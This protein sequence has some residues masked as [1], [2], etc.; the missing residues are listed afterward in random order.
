MRSYW[1]KLKAVSYWR[2]EMI[3]EVIA[4]GPWRRQ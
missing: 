1:K 4:L 3:K 2:G